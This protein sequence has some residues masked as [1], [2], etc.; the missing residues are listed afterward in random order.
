MDRKTEIHMLML[1]LETY[2]KEHPELSLE[3]VIL[4]IKEDIK[5]SKLEDR[6]AYY[7]LMKNIKDED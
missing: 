7:F 2:W 5:T 6:V 4:S 1:A 3:E